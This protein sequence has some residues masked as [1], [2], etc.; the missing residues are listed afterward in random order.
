MI[1]VETVVRRA[2][3]SPVVSVDWTC[4]IVVV[5]VYCCV[6]TMYLSWPL[7]VALELVVI[8]RVHFVPVDFDEN[9][10]RLDWTCR[11]NTL[12][13]RTNSALVEV[14]VVVDC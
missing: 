13:N 7:V 11:H 12:P 1:E 8:Q 14:V 6:A 9:D 10:E 4:T 5:A 2:V 3:Q